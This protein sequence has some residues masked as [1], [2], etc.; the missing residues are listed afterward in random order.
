MIHQGIW[1]DVYLKITGQHKIQDVKIQTKLFNYDTKAEIGLDIA[2]EGEDG[3]QVEGTFRT[4][5]FVE[6]Y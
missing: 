2:I 4:H 6:E 1:Q 5:D 3:C